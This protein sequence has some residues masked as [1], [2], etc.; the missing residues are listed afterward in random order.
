MNENSSDNHDL[1]QETRQFYGN[2]VTHLKQAGIPFLVG[3]AYALAHYTGVVRHTKDFDLFAHPRDWANLLDALAGA[4]YRTERTFPHWLGKVYYD[5]AFVDVIYSSGNGVAR[6]DDEWFRHAPRVEV[7]GWQVPV[8]PP[9][10]MIWSKAFVMERERYDG[11]DIA[12][13]LR[14]CGRHLDWAR[15]VR[16]FGPHWRLLLVNLVLFGFIY[17]GE[18][19]LIPRQVLNELLERLQSDRENTVPDAHL[20]QGT[21]LSREQY[22]A[23]IHR[24]G[25]R[26][27]R[28]APEGKMSAEAIAQWT[29]AI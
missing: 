20:C 1:D 10:E 18:Q 28:R 2:V 6:V 25:Y 3:G 12:H 14:S 11:A 22:L 23:D 26:D 5:G 27:A 19:G 16:R 9:E 13:L 4:G 8:V 24:W 17:P 29:A 15:L 7:L 21:L